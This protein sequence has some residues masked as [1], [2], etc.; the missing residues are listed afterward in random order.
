MQTG[1]SVLPSQY[2]AV[3]REDN[4]TDDYF[5]TIVPDPYRWLEDTDSNETLACAAV[6]IVLMSF[7]HACRTLR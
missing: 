6:N 2:P 4:V 3:R 1:L 7:W 5:G